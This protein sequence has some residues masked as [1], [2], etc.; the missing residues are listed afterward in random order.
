MSVWLPET[1]GGSLDFGMARA[2]MCRWLQ[3][4]NALLQFVDLTEG[5]HQ[6]YKK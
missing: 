4:S 5:G 2:A 1:A 3:A 6:S